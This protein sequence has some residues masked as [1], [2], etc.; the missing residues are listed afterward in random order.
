MQF[1][2]PEAADLHTIRALNVAFID[3]VAAGQLNAGTAGKTGQRL[4]ARIRELDSQRRARLADCPFLLHS[5]P[6][7]SAPCWSRL[8]T[9]APQD[10]LFAGQRGASVA[11][12][13]LGA[14]TLAFLWELS[15]RNPYA[16]RLV[17]GASLGWC[18]QLADCDPVAL[19]GFIAGESDMVF[20]RMPE[21][22]SFWTRMLEA[23]T[24]ASDE[25]R[26]AAHLSGLQTLLTA[27]GKTTYRRLPA[28]ACRMPARAM[29]VADRNKQ[30]PER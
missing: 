12:V 2:G 14:A 21:R 8:F 4:Y 11:L 1:Q 13:R 20:P 15:R 7:A 24:N 9:A 10:N 16:A 30:G 19:T 5:L 22:E 23:G 29:R 26:E 6:G 3:A 18:E 27:E 28:A 17:S 25:I